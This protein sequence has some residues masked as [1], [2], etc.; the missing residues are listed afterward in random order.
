M[1][2]RN[3]YENEIGHIA[4]PPAKSGAERRDETIQ[5]AR[6]LGLPETKSAPI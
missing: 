4:V 2:E 1:K 5:Q 6:A 3:K